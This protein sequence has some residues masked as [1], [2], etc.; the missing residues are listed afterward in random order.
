MRTV[1]A[2][3]KLATGNVG[4]FDPL[5]NIHLTI[6][7]PIADVY[8]GMN[9]TNLK[10]GVAYKTIMVVDGSLAEPSVTPTNEIASVPEKVVEVAVEIKEEIVEVQEEVIEEAAPVVEEVVEVQP[11]K[12]ATRKKKT[13]E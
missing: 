1:L 10:K 11:K 2:K 7:R 5:T 13:V 3:V 4:W 9:L 12:K 6:Q 8:E